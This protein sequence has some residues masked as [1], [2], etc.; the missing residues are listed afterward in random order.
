MRVSS[1]CSFF[2]LAKSDDVFY[3]NL[4][5]AFFVVIQDG[6]KSRSK[7]SLD[8]AVENVIQ[9]EISFLSAPRFI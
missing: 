9:G 5:Y 4:P 8:D 1:S 7:S 6:D 3:D 2:L